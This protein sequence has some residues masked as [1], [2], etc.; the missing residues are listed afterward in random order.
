[1]GNDIK[2]N[3]YHDQAVIKNCKKN[4]HNLMYNHKSVAVWGP[5]RA[6][7][8]RVAVGMQKKTEFLYILYEWEHCPELNI[9]LWVA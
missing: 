2:S 4:S 9:G 6:L 8:A 1:M 5:Q 7:K 3:L